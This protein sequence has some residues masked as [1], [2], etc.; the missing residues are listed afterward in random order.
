MYAQQINSP[1]CAYLK[2]T[3]VVCKSDPHLDPSWLV[4]VICNQSCADKDARRAVTAARDECQE[5]LSEFTE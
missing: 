5:R 4:E 3:A 1:M 2:Q